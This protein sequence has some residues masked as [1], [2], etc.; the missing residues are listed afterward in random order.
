MKLTAAEAVARF[1]AAQEIEQQGRRIPLFGGV[2]AIFGHGNVGGLGQALPAVEAR[3]PTLRGHDE[4]AMGH[5]A[6][7]FA[8]AWRRRRMMAVTTSIGPG[9]T[10]LVTAAA[11]AHVNRLPILLLPG[12]V[13][14][15]RGPDPVLQQLEHPL[16]RDASVNDCLRPVSRFFDRVTR[17]EQLLRSLPEAMR[18]LTDPAATGPATLALPQDAQA[19]RA[20]FPTDFFARRLHRVRRPPPEPSAVTE[21]AARL[22]RAARVLV[23]AGGGVRYAAAEDALRRL[24]EARGWPVAETQAGKGSLPHDHPLLVGALGVTGTSAANALVREADALLA[25]GTRL[26]D[27]T[28]GSA[29]LVPRRELSLVAVNVHPGDAAKHDAFPMVADARL[30]L[31]ALASALED[32]RARDG[33]WTARAQAA[34]G[35]WGEEVAAALD[36]PAPEPPSDAHVVRALDRLA[37]SETAVVSAAGGLPGELHKLWRARAPGRY[38]VEYGYSC[39]GHEIA[40]GL[41][42]K[43]ARPEL[44]VWVLVGDGAYLMLSTEIATSVALERPLVIWVLDNQGFGCIHRLDRSLRGE[45]RGA[46]GNLRGHP[47]IDLEAHARALGACAETV[48]L[49][50]AEAALARAREAG[51][52]SVIVIRTD[53]AAAPALGGA[54]WRVPSVRGGP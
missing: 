16:A 22:G 39:M 5:A 45:G 48:P 43:L 40:G 26:T 17:P 49:D 12:D 27:F 19:E 41:G 36:G 6:L 15:D 18:V 47:R 10:N 14:A 11:T 51:R 24:A 4:Q 2:W 23:V 32:G 52:T 54:P 28:T 35:A 38:L 8:K 20:A 46:S 53:P 44:E 37:G 42:V 1:V 25:V 9:A 34:R 31:E 30:G 50:A 7:G 29:R 13:F 21:A 33:G 3:L